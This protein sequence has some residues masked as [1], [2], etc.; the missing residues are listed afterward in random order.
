MVT[1]YPPGGRA[2]PPRGHRG[3]MT[4]QPDPA[5]GTLA[6]RARVNAASDRSTAESD[7]SVPPPESVLTGGSTTGRPADAPSQ[8]CAGDTGGAAD[9]EAPYGTESGQDTGLQS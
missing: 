6:E 4:T 3:D 8:P 5:D 7:G 2:T 1:E 9:P